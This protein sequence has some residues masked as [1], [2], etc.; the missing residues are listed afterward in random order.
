MKG[1]TEVSSL[2]WRDLFLIIAMVLFVVAGFRFEGKLDDLELQAGTF[3]A[4]G[5]IFFAGAFLSEVAS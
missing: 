5:L 2:R 1:Q 3:L 4:M